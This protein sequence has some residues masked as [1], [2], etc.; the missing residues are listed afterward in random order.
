MVGAGIVL[1]NDGPFVLDPEVNSTLKISVF[2][3]FEFLE[4]L[5]A[6]NFVLLMIKHFVI[7]YSL[8]K[9]VSRLVIS[10]A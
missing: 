4:M 1:N 6:I 3:V 2:H 8:Y 5:S 7:A 10:I 9:F